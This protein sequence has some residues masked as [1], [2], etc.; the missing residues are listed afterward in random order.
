MS[1][2]HL[3]TTTLQQYSS[4]NAYARGEDYF[5]SGAVV[6]VT[7]RQQ[8]LQ[9]VVEG[10]QP[11]PYRVTIAF[12]EGGITQAHCTCAYDW[13]G[14]CKHIVATLLTCIHQ[15]ERVEQRPTVQ[16]LL[17]PLNLEQTQHLVE[18]LVAEQPELIEWVD[19]SVSGLVRS[20]SVDISPNSSQRKTSVD[21]APFERQTRAVL[22]QALRE[23]EYGRE[24][25][26]IAIE[27]TP[28]IN[29]GLEFLEQG[30]AASALAVLEGITE[31]FAREWPEIDEFCGL[32]PTDIGLDL[33]AIWTEL[34]L[35][36]D[37][38]EEEVLVWQE[39][40]EAWQDYLNSFAMALEALRQG[41]NY[42]P[43]VRV[44]QGEVTAQRAWP[45]GAPDWAGDFCQIR[46][47]VLARQERYEEYLRL[48]RAEG[49]TEQY[50][51]MLAQLGRTEQAISVAQQQMNTMAQAQALA[52]T[53]RSQNQLPQALDIALEGLQLHAD[54][55]YQQF[56]FA[57]WT[58]DLAEGLGN[59]AAAL[60]ARRAA[61]EI[62]TSLPDYH[63][64][65]ELARADWPTLQP[66][67]L[68]ALRD[69][70]GWGIEKAKVD[71][72]LHEGLLAAAIATVAGLD[73]Y[74]SD[75]IWQVMDA[76][77]AQKN[78]DR[79]MLQWVID[80]ASPCAEAI[81]NKGKAK[82]YEQA[83]DWLKRVKVAFLALEKEADWS[84]YHQNLQQAHHRKRKL[85]G[86][87]Q[88]NQL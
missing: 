46:L 12:D 65:Q 73:P 87:M 20:G 32:M 43:L 66:Q 27:I 69:I 88:D 3:T 1:L 57:I 37:L 18:R 2:P 33:D 60:T 25:D 19:R 6:S 68:A 53:L 36:A 56:D 34:F 50:L 30:D 15:P 80:K 72:F 55:L 16:Q 11:T 47:K 45:G 38:N 59:L 7:Q 51:T 86:L 4:D 74:Y 75:V 77:L 29:T 22:R 58:S 31:G 78:A 8:T 70:Q 48:A 41:W 81:I 64:L 84:Q 14:W 24:D 82:N 39:N 62:Q 52:E 71:I 35:S 85:M 76:V 26:D 13:G 61:F 23:W 54:N 17:E 10:N 42:P 5:R 28:L 79:A 44:L 67:L 49:Q 83:V 9:A 63:K 21:P 40:L